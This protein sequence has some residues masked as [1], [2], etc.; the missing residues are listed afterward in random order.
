MK[1]LAIR[2]DQAG[3]DGWHVLDL[4]TDDVDEANEAADAWEDENFSTLGC[5]QVF[6]IDEV[7]DLAKICG[8]VLA[9]FRE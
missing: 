4:A 8:E 7:K 6:S 1:W 2:F 9:S 3:I 5:T